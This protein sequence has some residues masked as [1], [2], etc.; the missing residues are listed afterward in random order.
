MTIK[1]LKIENFRNVKAAQ[2]DFCEGINLL[3]GE[4]AQGKTN[5]LEGGVNA[6]P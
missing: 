6:K 4:N 2:I 3:K 5:A 1:S